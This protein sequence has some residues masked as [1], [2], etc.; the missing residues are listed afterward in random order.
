MKIK[1]I[2]AISFA[3]VSLLSIVTGTGI[4]V[5]AAENTTNTPNSDNVSVTNSAFTENETDPSNNYIFDSE[6]VIIEN[7]ESGI[8]VTKYEKSNSSKDKLQVGFRHKR[9]TRSGVLSIAGRRSRTAGL[10]PPVLTGG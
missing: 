7:T 2:G 4:S 9:I 10:K 8:E 1:K 3:A 6:N 5:Y